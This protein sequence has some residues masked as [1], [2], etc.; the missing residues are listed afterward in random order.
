MTKGVSIGAF[1]GI[2]CFYAT[3]ENDLKIKLKSM[4]IIL[5][6]YTSLQK[7]LLCPLT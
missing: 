5:L 1:S 3:D 7:C 6:Y 2:T 4:S